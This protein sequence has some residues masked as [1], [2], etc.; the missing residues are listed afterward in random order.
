MIAKTV[1]HEKGLKWMRNSRL[2]SPSPC[3]QSGL[4]TGPSQPSH[5][6]GAS[7]LSTARSLSGSAPCRLALNFWLLDSVT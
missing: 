7:I 3:H 2:S 1:R 4:S 5:R 6:P